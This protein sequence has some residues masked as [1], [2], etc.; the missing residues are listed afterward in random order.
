MSL[1]YFLSLLQT[2]KAPPLLL[3]TV[4]DKHPDPLHST[5]LH[6]HLHQS[7]HH[8]QTVVKTTIGFRIA[9]VGS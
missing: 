5:L 3:R 2:T 4:I 9:I 8:Q 6:P 7:H 1:L